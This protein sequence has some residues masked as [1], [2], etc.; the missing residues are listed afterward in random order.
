MTIPTPSRPIVKDY[1]IPKDEA[2][3]LDWAYVSQRMVESRNYWIAT[4]GK[5]GRPHA[6]PVWGVWSDDTLY[7]G[8]GPDTRWARNLAQNPEVAVHLEDGD[9][10]V[11]LKGSVTAI[12]DADALTPI[13][14]LYE[15]KYNIRHGPTI[16]VLQPRLVFAWTQFPKT[17]TRWLF[18]ESGE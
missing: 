17:M 9:E 7:F 5:D 8:G 13:D 2:G 14:D 6:V 11:I 18:G 1:G 4:A 10:A 16:W 12:R 3:L 15:V